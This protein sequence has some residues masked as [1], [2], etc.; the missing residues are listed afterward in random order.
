MA[1]ISGSLNMQFKSSH[2]NLIKFA[3]IPRLLRTIQ[4]YVKCL[5]AVFEEAFI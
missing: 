4:D 3:A 1:L 5:H 2:S